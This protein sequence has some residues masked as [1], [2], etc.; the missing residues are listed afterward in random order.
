MHFLIYTA[1]RNVLSHTASLFTQCANK[2]DVITCI[3]SPNGF[4]GYLEDW[5]YS[6]D[7][8]V[9]EPDGS[10]FTADD[11]LPYV[12]TNYPAIQLVY[13]YSGKPLVCSNHCIQH[14]ALLTLP[15]DRGMI[16]RAMAECRVRSDYYRR[17]GIFF[18][19]RNITTYIP[20]GSILYIESQARS[21]RVYTTD[22]EL[23]I[24][25]PLSSV[26]K[27]LDGRFIKC[28]QS[29]AVNVN[30][31]RMYICD[32]ADMNYACLELTNGDRIPVSVRRQK[33]TRSFYEQYC[34]SLLHENS[35]Y[36]IKQN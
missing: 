20:L 32:P 14:S 17:A 28:H 34:K 24:N 15:L 36:F 27:R 19:D 1:D 30:Y 4:L 23:T 9:T 35:G 12:K 16:S 3:D 6:V 22:G 11:M 29:F 26:E 13:L 33:Q 2:D 5:G 25:E 21:V 31:T 18:S 10:N 8:L 7:V